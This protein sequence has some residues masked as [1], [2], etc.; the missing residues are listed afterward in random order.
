M[1]EDDD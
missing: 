1:F